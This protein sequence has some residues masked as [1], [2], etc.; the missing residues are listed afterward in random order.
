MQIEKFLDTIR[1]DMD[2]FERFWKEGQLNNKNCFPHEMLGRD[3]Y[4]Q[5][6]DF[7]SS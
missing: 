6:I 3:W 1:D 4:E 7:L 2:R 5:W